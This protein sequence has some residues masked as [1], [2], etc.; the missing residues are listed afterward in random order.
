M[1]LQSKDVVTESILQEA[2]AGRDIAAANVEQAKFS[3]EL[4][5]IDL[6]HLTQKAPFSGMMSAPLVM[7]NGWQEVSGR[8]HIRMAV[9]TQL[10]PIHVVG[11]IPYSVFAEHH[12]IPETGEAAKKRVVLSI[13]LPDGDIYPYEG[14]LVS[15]GYKFDEDTQKITVWAEFPNPD[16]LLHP[17]LA[18]KLR[19]LLAKQ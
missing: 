5:E 13:V 8:E 15:G 6:S 9:I 16:L 4:L 19:S 10:D 12:R 17:G 3:I 14:R 2:E 7:E 18:V 11:K 1:T